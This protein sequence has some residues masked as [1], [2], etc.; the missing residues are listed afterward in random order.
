MRLSSRGESTLTLT[1]LFIATHGYF[2]AL[3]E[4]LI[5]TYWDDGPSLEVFLAVLAHG[6]APR[7]RKLNLYAKKEEKVNASAVVAVLAWALETRA[8]KG[9]PALAELDLGVVRWATDGPLDVRRR[10][11]SVLLP[12]VETT[13]YS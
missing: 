13:P 9:C 8:A 2:P 10:V 7:L 12:T 5:T 1:H 6:A 4:L 3:E 11:W